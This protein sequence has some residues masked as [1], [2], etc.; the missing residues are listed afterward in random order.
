M[1]KAPQVCYKF[2]W[3]KT[4]LY[5]GDALPHFNLGL[6]I[7]VRILHYEDGCYKRVGFCKGFSVF[8]LQQGSRV[9]TR[10]KSVDQRSD[11]KLGALSDYGLRIDLVDKDIGTQKRILRGIVAFIKDKSESCPHY[12]T[13]FVSFCR[14]FWNLKYTHSNEKEEVGLHA[15]GKMRGQSLRQTRKRF[16][17]K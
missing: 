7:T 14:D 5:I 10:G 2:Y 17:W 13:Y 1:V 9:E 3:L 12:S 4:Q 15:V 16:D 6:Y 8:K 11:S